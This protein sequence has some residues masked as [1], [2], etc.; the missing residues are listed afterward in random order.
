MQW[1][2]NKKREAANKRQQRKQQSTN[3]GKNSNR[4]PT[5]THNAKM[6]SLTKL[7]KCTKHLASKDFRPKQSIGHQG[8]HISFRTLGCA[9]ISTTTPTTSRDRITLGGNSRTAQWSLTQ[10]TLCKRSPLDSW[11]RKQ[12]AGQYGA[13][14]FQSA[15]QSLVPGAGHVLLLMEGCTRGM[16]LMEA[17]CLG[18][19]G[20]A[21]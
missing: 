7:S 21:L 13:V 15:G 3:S 10:E 14:P 11:S 2:A 12:E 1:T 17:I 9:N 4:K 19:L 20:K 6:A 18:V 16:T 5:T 8:W